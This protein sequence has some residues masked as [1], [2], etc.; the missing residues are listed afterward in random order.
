MAGDMLP[1]RLSFRLTIGDRDF[2]RAFAGARFSR[3]FD[4]DVDAEGMAAA[5]RMSGWLNGR[6]AA[7]ASRTAASAYPHVQE[8][9]RALRGTGNDIR[10][11]LES[12]AQLQAPRITPQP[13]RHVTG[14]ASARQ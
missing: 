9:G 14:I 1:Q 4:V 12:I 11:V 8:A 5:A 13:R 2:L 3:L 7:K 6:P 10:Q